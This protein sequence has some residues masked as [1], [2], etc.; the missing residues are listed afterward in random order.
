MLL[1]LAVG[2]QN[3]QQQEFDEFLKQAQGEFESYEKQINYEFAE[4]LRTQWEEFQVFKG[5]E[6]PVKP[7]PARYMS[8]PLKQTLFQKSFLQLRHL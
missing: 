1:P 7:K 4:A 8:P 6:I 5:E 2:A 3:G